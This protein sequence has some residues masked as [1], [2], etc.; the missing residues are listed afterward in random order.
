MAPCSKKRYSSALQAAVVLRAIRSK[1]SST[2]RAEV[3]IHP[4]SECHGFH[5]TSDR[6]SAKNK[7]TIGA[8]QKL[9]SSAA[10]A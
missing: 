10:G 8:M 7:W 1:S 3:G 5:L 4:C 2:C 9:N 6:K